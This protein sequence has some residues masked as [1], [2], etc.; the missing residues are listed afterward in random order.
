ME[1]SA[2][3]VSGQME[4]HDYVDLGLPS[5]TKWATCNVGANTPTEY[6][7][8]LLGEKQSRRVITKLRKTVHGWLLK[9]VIL[10]RST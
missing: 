6:G 4:G 9:Q 7:E 5:G 2:Q 8:Y 10:K 3:T 1:C